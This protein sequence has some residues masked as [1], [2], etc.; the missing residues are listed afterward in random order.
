MCGRIVCFFLGHPGLPR[1]ILRMLE[2]GWITRC[3][4]CGKWIERPDVR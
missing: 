1:G 3:V 4:R 2:H